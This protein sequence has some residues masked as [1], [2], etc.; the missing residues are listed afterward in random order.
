ML[1][2]T[3]IRGELSELTSVLM[4]RCAPLMA[5]SRTGASAAAKRLLLYWTAA[6]YCVVGISLPD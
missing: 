5:L 3:L 2:G 1:S 4:T 6:P